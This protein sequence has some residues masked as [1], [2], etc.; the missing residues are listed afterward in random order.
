V[1]PTGPGYS[2]CD[3]RP[4]PGSLPSFDIVTQTVNGPIRVQFATNQ[5]AKKL[6]ISLPSGVNARLILPP[7]QQLAGLHAEPSGKATSYRLRGPTEV[8]GAILK[9]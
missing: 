4:Q 5:G 3:I 1:R 7:Q 9:R 8:G 2:E 6:Y